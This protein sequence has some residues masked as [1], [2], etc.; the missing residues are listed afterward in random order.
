MQKRPGAPSGGKLYRQV[1]DQ[2]LA[3]IKSGKIAIGDALPPEP[4]LAQQYEVSRHTMREALRILRELGVVDRR[5]GAGTVV[6]A[7]APQ[8]AYVQVIRS[9]SELLQYPPSRLTVRSTETVR[10]DRKLAK[11]LQCRTGERWVHV[12]A[13]RSLR[14]KRTPIH[15][16]DTY[17]LPEYAGIVPWIGKRDQYLY[18]MISEKY[19][20]VATSVLMD[21]AGSRLSP[22]LAMELDAEAGEPS[23]RIIRRYA[24]TGQ[25]VYLISISEHPVHRYSFRLQLH[26]GLSAAGTWSVG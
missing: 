10:A 14:G 12:R 20:E 15:W 19:G 8:P 9:P 13:V 4:E 18:E 1:A 7:R 23:L 25:R 21:L 5:P 17:M 22:E 16:L 26:H 3:R 11:Q 6:K 24:G 2:L